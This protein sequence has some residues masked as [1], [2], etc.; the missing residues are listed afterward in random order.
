M[1]PPQGIAI[2]Y[3]GF[4]VTP[5]GVE[6]IRKITLVLMLMALMFSLSASMVNPVSSAFIQPADTPTAVTLYPATNTTQSSAVLTWSPGSYSNFSRY[7]VRMTRIPGSYGCSCTIVASIYSWNV[8]SYTA[9]GMLANTTYYFTTGLH[10][11]GLY[12]ASQIAS[13]RKVPRIAHQPH[14]SPPELP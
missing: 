8:T 12:A 10:S 2:I 14:I 4:N 1:V 5:C 13:G 11:E 7:E 6:P 3:K 9:T